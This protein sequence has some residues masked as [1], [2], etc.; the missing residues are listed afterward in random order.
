MD[1]AIKSE[2]SSI[3][4]DL[5]I[6]KVDYDSETELKK[7]Y[8]ITYQHTLVQVDAQGNQIT[9]WTGGSDLNSIVSRLK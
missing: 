6:L 5:T 7:K 4:S 2:M 9:K 3:P 1:A 8:S